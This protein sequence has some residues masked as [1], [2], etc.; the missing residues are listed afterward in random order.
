MS[1]RS[2]WISELPVPLNSSKMTRPLRE[3]GVDERGGDDGQRAPSSMLRAAPKKRFGL[4]QRVRVDAAGE[5][6]ARR[7]GRRVCRRG[8]ARDRVEQDDHVLPISAEL[9]LLDHI[10]ATAQCVRVLVEG[11]GHTSPPRCA[12]CR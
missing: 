7:R 5:D 4:V 1:L 11:R 2:R 10:S 12:A 9:G 6:L 3:A 8:E